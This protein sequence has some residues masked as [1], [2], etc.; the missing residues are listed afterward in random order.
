MSAISP[1]LQSQQSLG[2]KEES[3]SKVNAR[4]KSILLADDSATIRRLI[5]TLLQG[6]TGCEI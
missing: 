4:A 2:I 5:R 6:Q 3:A 1:T